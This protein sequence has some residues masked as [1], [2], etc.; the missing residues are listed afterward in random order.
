M[1]YLIANWKMNPGSSEEAKE[2]F[3]N[4]KQGVKDLSAEVVICPPS[5]YYFPNLKSKGLKLHLG[6]Q[7]CFWEQ[8]GAY[9]GE[10]SPKMLKNM[11]CKYVILGHSERRQYLNET[12][13]M[14]NK[15]LKAVLEAGLTPI[16]CVGETKQERDR[17]EAEKKIKSQLKFLLQ[18]SKLILAYEPRWAIGT[19]I[20]CN[21]E[22]AK[23]A[24]N[25]IKEV[26]QE[27]PVLYGGSVSAEN[28]KQY[29]DAG[30]NG[31]LVGSASLNAP[32]FI[33]IAKTI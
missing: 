5:I 25:M 9:T 21:P 33:K 32:E 6:A 31:L 14:V 27:T 24:L 28:A 29:I 16:L 1:K 8:A 18:N 10:I 12:D 23:K 20:A 11:G 4:I 7:N 2:L 30:F 15:K 22:S 3:N 26:A 13:E 17:G 19:G